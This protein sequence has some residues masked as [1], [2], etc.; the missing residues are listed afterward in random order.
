M[1][2]ETHMASGDPPTLAETVTPPSSGQSPAKAA[3]VARLKAL[4]VFLGVSVTDTAKIAGVSRPYLSRI[5][6]GDELLKPDHM[7]RQIEL[8]FGDLVAR[9]TKAIFD[10]QAS[11]VDNIERM[12]GL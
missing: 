3:N 12:A 4:M 11:A 7:F 8:R 9:R 6:N 10:L 1:T 5:L 2:I